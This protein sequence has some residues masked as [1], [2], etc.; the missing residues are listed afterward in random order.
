L[1]SIAAPPY[2]VTSQSDIT[3]NSFIPTDHY[4]TSLQ[5]SN[6]DVWAYQFAAMLGLPAEVAG[7]VP[8]EVCARLFDNGGGRERR[9]DLCRGFQT[10]I[11]RATR[12]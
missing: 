5:Y 7:P 9:Y 1:G 6:G 12:P 4:A 10:A 2:N 11:T 8:L 3:S